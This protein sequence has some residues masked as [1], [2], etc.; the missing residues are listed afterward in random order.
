[1]RATKP[2]GQEQKAEMSHSLF[3]KGAI[4]SPSQEEAILIE[5][6][7]EELKKQIALKERQLADMTGERDTVNILRSRLGLEKNFTPGVAFSNLMRDEQQSKT[8]IIDSSRQRGQYSSS[9]PQN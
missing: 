2:F 1:M 4:V 7:H 5:Q 9:S 6:R 3:S 8:D